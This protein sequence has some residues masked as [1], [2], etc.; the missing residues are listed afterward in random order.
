MFENI[1]GQAGIGQLSRDI[2]AGALA[3]SLLFSGPP[4]SGKGTAGLEL[5]RILSCE[6]PGAPWNCICPACTHHRTLTHPDL[7]LLGPR[8]FSP[9]I[10]AAAAAYNRE[11]ES[12]S[13]R[14]LFVRSVRKLLARFSPVLWEDD[15][16]QGKLSSAQQALE[17]DLDEIALTFSPPPGSGG[18]PVK[19]EALKKICGRIIKEALKLE[20]EGIGK[21]VPIAQLRRAAYWGRLA[22]SGRHKL[23]MIENAHRMQEEARNSILKLLE[24]PPLT[25]TI[26]LTCP[27]PEALIPTILSRLRPYRFYPRDQ[28]AEEEVIRRVFREKAGESPPEGA[29]PPG[30]AASGASRIQGYLDSFLP[31]TAEDLFPLA[32][33]FASSVTAA[34]LAEI[35]RKG[36]PLPEE[37]AVLDRHTAAIAEQGGRENGGDIR[38]VLAGTL[39]GA[40][41]FEIPGLFS[42]FLGLLLTLVSAALREDP[43]GPEKIALGDIWLRAVREAETA[44]GTYNQRPPV[45]LDRLFTELRQAMTAY[46]LFSG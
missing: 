35:R 3:P 46:A 21:T 28:E 16:K 45:V 39:S 34:S 24:E 10:A 7:L 44:A 9:E 32:A 18:E 15:P 30:P 19:A 12:V 29:L 41:N 6:N 37:L 14:L 31:V 5:A 27:Q 33:C 25:L 11:P 38:E 22:P 26:L 36:G 17:E 4:A 13:A 1:L 43:P 23:L 42:R 8:S 40:Q 20:A 2:A